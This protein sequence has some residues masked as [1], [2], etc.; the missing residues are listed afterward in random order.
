MTY[1]ARYL[2]PSGFGVLSFALAFTGI[3]A[4]FADFGLQLLI[5]REVARDKNLT[6]KYLANFSLMKIILAVFAYGLIAII[7][8][9]MAY[10]WQ[11]ILV[12]YL[13][14]VYVICSAFTQMFYSTF[15]A[16]ERMEFQAIGQFLNSVLML[17]SIVVA[18]RLGLDI[19]IFAYIYV[20]VALVT[21]IYSYI[22]MKS[23]FF[24]YSVNWVPNMLEMDRDF[25]KLTFKRVLP[26]GLSQV[27]VTSFYWISTILLSLMK[28]DAMVGWY[29][30]SYRMVLI[31]SFIPAAVI[32]AIYPVMAKLFVTSQDTL[33]IVH[34]RSLK[35]LATLAIPLGIGTTIL[36]S[37]FISL[38]FGSE[39]A[40]S[41]TVLQILVWSEVCIFI[42]MPL[43]NL[44][45]SMNKQLLTMV[46]TA[47][48][49]IINVVFNLALIPQYGLIGAS[50]TTVLTEAVSLIL[51]LVFAAGMSHGFSSKNIKYLAKVITAS[52]LM[53]LYILLIRELNLILIIVSSVL[54]Y[55]LLLY[56]IK[57]IGK[58]DINLIKLA[59]NFK[60]Y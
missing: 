12:V 24:E 2:G 56:A 7:I 28:G 15:Q 25:W 13:L 59:V 29:N 45:N 36:A 22:V 50:A 60:G 32:A 51:C 11:T 26:F 40:E 41:V 42:S 57:G 43:A 4:V 48:C 14:G 52:I 58:E 55:F 9:L 27:F 33:K 46:I 47:I 44:F 31:L 5:T 30:A 6:Q 49:L 18:I 35:Y 8:N 1:I 54:L 19:V 53:G 34:E 21:L 20:A 38:I 10:P 39:Y 23:L 16:Y 37:R 17:V 3:F